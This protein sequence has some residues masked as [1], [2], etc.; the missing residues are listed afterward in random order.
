VADRVDSAPST[1]VASKPAE[2][3]PPATDTQSPVSAP[4]PVP[5][6]VP[7]QP[8]PAAATPADSANAA[9][10]EH[11]P[12]AMRDGVFSGWGTSRH[13]D[14][15]AAV[16]IKNGRITAAYITQC[17]T[18]YSCDWIADLPLQVVMRQSP[19][20]DFVSGA[21]QSTNAFYYAIAEALNKAK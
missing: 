20:V 10:G 9:A 11:Q 17:L 4:V 21:T 19:E 5:A 1:I 3:A 8:A 18:R 2:T 13:G 7:V 14:I 6:A 12:P 15:Q 16:Q